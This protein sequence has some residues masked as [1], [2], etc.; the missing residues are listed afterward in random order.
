LQMDSEGGLTIYIQNAPPGREKEPNWLPSTKS[1]LFILV[2]RTYMPG[3]AI[4]DQR[5]APPSVVQTQ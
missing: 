4:V 3:T 5:W 2:M 1:G